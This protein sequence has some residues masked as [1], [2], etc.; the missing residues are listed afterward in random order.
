MSGGRTSYDE[1]DSPAVMRLDAAAVG[2]APGL[3]SVARAAAAGAPSLEYGARAREVVKRQLTVDEAAA[4][5]ANALN[6]YLD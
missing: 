2:R 5:L 1:I 3:E 4:T 6:L